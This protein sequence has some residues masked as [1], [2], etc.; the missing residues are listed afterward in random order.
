MR[1]YYPKR[2][3]HKLTDPLAMAMYTIG[4]LPFMPRFRCTVRVKKNATISKNVP[5][6]DKNTCRT[7]MVCLWICAISAGIRNCGTF[8]QMR[9]DFCQTRRNSANAL[10]FHGKRLYKM[11][12]MARPSK[13]GAHSGRNTAH[14]AAH[15]QVPLRRIF[16]FFFTCIISQ[17]WYICICG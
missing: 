10:H 17:V 11:A 14:M 4:I 9:R 12:H 5:L 15:F 3:Q 13:C 2:A 7:F 1:P 16:C 8:C 6:F